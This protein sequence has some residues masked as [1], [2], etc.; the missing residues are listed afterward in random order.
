MARNDKQEAWEKGYID[1]VDQMKQAYDYRQDFLKDFNLNGE[2]KEDDQIGDDSGSGGGGSVTIGTKY[3]DV[4]NE[5]GK[6]YGINPYFIASVIKQESNFNPSAG[7]HAG[8][9]GLMQLMPATARALGVSNPSDPRQNV[10]GGTKYLKQMLQAQGWN[11]VLALAAYN[12]GPGN[13]RKYGGVP[14]FKE[15]QH[16][17]KVIPQNFKNYTGET[18]TSKNVKWSGDMASSGGKTSFSG[19]GSQITI[20]GGRIYIPTGI[21][22]SQYAAKRRSEGSSTN[23]AAWKKLDSKKFNH[24]G[25]MKS[26]N[27]YAPD[28]H[29]AFN[30]LYEK[31]GKKTLLINSGFRN[32]DPAMHGAGCA[33]DIGCRGKKDALFVADTAWSLGFRGIGVGGNLGGGA[34]FVHVDIGPDGGGWSYGYGKYRGPN[35]MR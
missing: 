16:Y 29:A 25:P 34:G 23:W 19:S 28:A 2:K 8:A 9:K 30:L 21:G 35:S 5:A 22:R 32:G 11:P 24:N 7:S 26:V 13:V 10:M 3:D 14:P 27:K 31:L 33:F 1:N 12:A 17:V 4:I 18:L 20:K 6:K 15:T